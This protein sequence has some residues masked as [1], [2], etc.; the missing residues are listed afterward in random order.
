MLIL[1]SNYIPVLKVIKKLNSQN[2]IFNL[3]SHENDKKTSQN[4]IF[5]LFSH[6]NGF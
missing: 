6:E 5:N 1:R 3:F 2:Y 4:Y